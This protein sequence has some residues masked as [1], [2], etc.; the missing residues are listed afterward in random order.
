M[1][2]PIVRAG[3]SHPCAWSSSALWLVLS[4]MTTSTGLPATVMPGRRAAGDARARYLR[5]WR[6]EM[7]SAA[8]FGGLAALERNARRRRAYARLAEVEAR[9]A[10][11]FARE[12]ERAG[13]TLPPFE[14]SRR[15]R[16]LLALARRFGTVAVLPRIAMLECADA[17]G[18]RLDDPELAPYEEEHANAQWLAEF[19]SAE[20][21]EAMQRLILRGRRFVIACVGAV[22]FAASVFLARNAQLEGLVFGLLGGVMVGPV[23]HYLLGKVAIPFG[24]GRVW[25]GWACWTAAVL[26]Q[27]PYRS[28]PGSPRSGVRR[29]RYATFGATI[30]LVLALAFGLGYDGGGVGAHAAAWFVAGN[31][32]YWLVGV[33]LAVRLRDNRAFCKVAC[34]VAVL[35]RVT[36]RPA[37]VKVA[38][39]AS[40]CVDCRSKACAT[41]CPMDVDVPSYVS[42]GRR[43]LASECIMCQHCVAV[44]PPNTLTLSVGFDLAVADVL[45]ER[46]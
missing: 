8:L 6:Q 24:V 2:M 32:L 35:L 42:S 16:V 34:P 39:A 26:D 1:P 38:G 7:E 22:L 11:R 36:A 14:P 30:A 13:L 31:A 28:S 46:A 15:T 37:L 18:Y 5:H 23:T 29:I 25:C 10:E 43:V 33:V 9:H 41:Q 4:T 44:C 3:T 21:G 45:R 17:R 40:A 12:L 20:A 27:L 19:A